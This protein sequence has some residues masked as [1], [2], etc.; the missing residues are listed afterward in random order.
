MVYIADAI[1]GSR[2]GARYEDYG[3]Y[4]ARLEK[5]EQLAKSFKGVKDVYAIQAGREVRVIVNPEKISDAETVKLATD[6]RDKIK[7]EM[8]YP[9]QVKVTVIREKRIVKVAK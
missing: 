1:S 8:T 7:K 9:G 3:E 5:L 4:V 6:L 2:P